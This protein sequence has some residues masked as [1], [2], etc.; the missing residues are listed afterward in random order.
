MELGNFS[1]SFTVKDL[2]TSLAFYQTFGFKE[3]AGDAS[4]NWLILGNGDAKIGIFQGMFKENMITFN[5][6]DARAVQAVIKA[7]NYPL[8]KQAE[9]GEGPAH[10]VVKDPDGNLILV[11]QHE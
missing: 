5:P 10:F 1:V 2:A 6:P 4:Q 9:E 11:D 7:A 8:E 3:I